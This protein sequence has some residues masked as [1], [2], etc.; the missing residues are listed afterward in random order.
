MKVL[1]TTLAAA[2]IA[3][4]AATGA[5]AVTYTNIS[6]VVYEGGPGGI[7]PAAPAADHT[8][9]DFNG[10]SF[11]PILELIG[12]TS[13]YGSVQH[14][15]AVAFRD[16]WTI[17]FGTGTY[18][19]EFNWE[20]ISSVFDGR[21]LVNGVEYLTNGSGSFDLGLMTG[22]VAFQFDPVFGSNP[23]IETA[24]WD[25]QMAAVPLPAAGLLLLA[26]LG[27]LAATRRRSTDA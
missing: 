11:D 9:G 16:G 8:L 10:A 13:I 20:M 17:D 7:D 4:G 23:A 21:L 18:D 24:Y 15:N 27:G 6:G 26:A 19:V 14:Q 1:K 25:L 3:A 2:A 12:D 22:V 5:S